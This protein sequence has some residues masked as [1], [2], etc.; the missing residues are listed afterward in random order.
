MQKGSFG[1]CLMKE[2]PLVRACMEEMA[3]AVSI[4]CTV[5]CRLGVDEFD[6]YEFLVDFIKE[7]SGDSQGPIKNFVIHARKALLKGLNPAQN[8]SIPPLIY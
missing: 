4:K 1:A 7:V 5:K 2:P 8:R 6:S 3:K